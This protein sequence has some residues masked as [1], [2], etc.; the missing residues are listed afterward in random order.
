MTGKYDWILHDY[1]KHVSMTSNSEI[2]TS[3]LTR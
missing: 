2:L 1:Y 3:S